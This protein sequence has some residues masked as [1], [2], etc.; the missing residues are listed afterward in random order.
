MPGHGREISERVEV[1]DET[2][3]SRQ[4]TRSM[5]KQKSMHSDTR[6]YRDAYDITRAGQSFA[7]TSLLPASGCRIVEG[8]RRDEKSDEM[9]MAGKGE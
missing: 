3:D 6:H 2:G 9:Q 4:T 1:G 5:D 7:D 8:E